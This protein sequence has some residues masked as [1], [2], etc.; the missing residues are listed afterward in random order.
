MGGRYARRAMRT[1]EYSVLVLRLDVPARRTLA[2]ALSRVWVWD[3]I[4]P[5]ILMGG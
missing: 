3:Y 1:L 5:V 2:Q 4:A